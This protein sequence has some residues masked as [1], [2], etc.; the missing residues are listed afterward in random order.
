MSMKEEELRAKKAN[1][2]FNTMREAANPEGAKVLWYL[3]E[4]GADEIMQLITERDAAIRIDETKKNREACWYVFDP[5]GEGETSSDQL[6]IDEML[7]K[8]IAELEA[9][10]RKEEV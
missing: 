4:E 8:R 7:G 10:K 5:N 3:G 1:H 2:P 6:E 9:I